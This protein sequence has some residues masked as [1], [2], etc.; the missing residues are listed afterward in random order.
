MITARTHGS[1]CAG[2]ASGVTVGELALKWPLELP[3]LA[4][5]AALKHAEDD[6]YSE[7]AR[8]RSGGGFA[9]RTIPREPPRPVR[10]FL[11]HE[12]LPKISRKPTVSPDSIVSPLSSRF[13]CVDPSGVLYWTRSAAKPKRLL[14]D[15][16]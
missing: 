14:C 16:W 10:A 5:D 8:S 7:A 9:E 1:H 6:P 2:Y 13:R 15:L 11:Q 4:V 3:L 12:R